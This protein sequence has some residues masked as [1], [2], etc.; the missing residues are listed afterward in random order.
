M[1]GFRSCIDT[2]VNRRPR[3]GPPSYLAGLVSG[4]AITHAGAVDGRT[5]LS[6]GR[7]SGRGLRRHLDPRV[8]FGHRHGMDEEQGPYRG[9]VR[10][11]MIALADLTVEVR[12]ILRYI[13]GDDD[14]E[15]TQDIPDS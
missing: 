7:S 9:E 4:L 12:T 2:F 6:Y 3:K 5:I 11:I 8:L 1:S 13:E 15:E 14:E 10:S